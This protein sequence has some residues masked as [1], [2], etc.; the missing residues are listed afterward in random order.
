MKKWITPFFASMLVIILAAC[1]D[2]AEP[3]AGSTNDSQLTLEEVYQK[4]LDRQNELESVSAIVKMDQA[5]TYG[6]GE[7]SLEI[8]SKSDMTM[9]MITEPLTMYMK[10]TMGMADSE[11][12]EDSM[13]D[14]EMYMTK[15]GL[16]MQDSLSNQWTKMPADDF[17]AIMGQAASQV[18]AAE[19]LEQ[20][21]SFVSDFKFEQTDSTYVLTL[22]A[23]SEK[24]NEF[25][26]EQLNVNE[27]VGITGDEQQ[28]LQNTKFEKVDYEIIID[29]ETFNISE[30]VMYVDF[31]M[32]I[33]GNSIK[34]VSDTAITFENFNGV[35]AISIPQEVIDKAVEI[36][37]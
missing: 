37:Y 34:T 25:M 10:G 16:F 14:L 28:L 1:N 33:E 27:M 21:K 13:I 4:A 30:M 15:E 5:M 2:T 6:A 26:L 3:Q 35:D 36:E 19:Q 11:A 29:K 12:E 7:E 31:T 24:F 32:D 8:K 20:M 22:N 17:D 23:S 9:D 18:N